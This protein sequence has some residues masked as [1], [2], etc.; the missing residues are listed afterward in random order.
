[1]RRIV[2][3]II[4]TIAVSVNCALC[5]HSKPDIDGKRLLCQPDTPPQVALNLCCKFSDQ[6]TPAQSV[7]D[8]QAA[9]EVSE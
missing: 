1:M 8:Q 9:L 6:A 4:M 3:T 7:S 2:S 5:T